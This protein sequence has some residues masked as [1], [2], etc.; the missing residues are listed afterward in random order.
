M[1]WKTV[2]A[3]VAIGIGVLAPSAQAT[4]QSGDTAIVTLGDSFIS[5]EAGRW[6]GNSIVSTTDRA[7]TDRAWTG[8]GYDPSRIYGATDANGCHRS[9]VSEVDSATVAVA[10]EVNLAC[11]GAVT[12]N[13]FRPSQGGQRPERRALAGTEAALRGAGAEREGRG[14]V[15]RR[16]R[17]GL[18]RH[19]PRLRPGVRRARPGPA[20][21][22]SS[23][24]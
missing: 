18:R 2:M 11:S 5:G 14:A 16:Q 15:D 13:I 1:K 21:P 8:T 6:Q 3:G 24:W 9:D 23:R 20:T 22:P 17:P 7:G 19:H 10:R 4:P 12:A